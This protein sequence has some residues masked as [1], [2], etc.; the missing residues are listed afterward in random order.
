M[1]SI[2]VASSYPNASTE[3]TRSPIPS[4]S[5]DFESD[6]T[7][8]HQAIDALTDDNLDLNRGSNLDSPSLL[9]STNLS[10]VASTNQSINSL[11]A[12]QTSTAMFAVDAN[13][14]TAFKTNGTNA[15]DLIVIGSPGNYQTI[16]DSEDF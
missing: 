1:P 12:L 4:T 6:V 11:P 2:N 8:T 5:A 14:F 7:N 3:K 10:T 15:R 13:R 9:T 16:A